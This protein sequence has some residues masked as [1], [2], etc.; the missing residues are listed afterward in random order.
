MFLT[1][2]YIIFPKRDCR[3]LPLIITVKADLMKSTFSMK[4][5]S[6]SLLKRDDN[7]QASQQQ[8]PE[9]H[10]LKESE[11]MKPVH[12]APIIIEQ[13]PQPTE[14]ASLNFSAIASEPVK[15]NVDENPEAS[16]TQ[17]KQSPFAF[18]S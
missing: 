15:R 13:V 18:Q 17:P 10:Y 8:S 7:C 12:E 2:S 11:I 9:E 5:P 4:L 1:I 14:T 6:T 3:K 16:E